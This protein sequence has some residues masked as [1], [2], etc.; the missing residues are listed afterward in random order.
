MSEY[1]K[2]D[3]V[4]KRDPATKNKTLILNDFSNPAFEYL[5]HNKWAFTEKVDGT[6]IRV[7]LPKYHENGL[8]YGITFGGKTEEAQIHTKLLVR[9]QERFMTVERRQ[10]LA[11]M[12]PHGAVLYGEGFGLGIQ[13][14]GQHYGAHQDFVLFDV[15][16]NDADT[17]GKTWW[18]ERRNVEDVA[19]KLDLPVVPIIGEGTLFDMVRMVRE[20]FPSQWG[21]EHGSFPAEGIVARPVV[22]LTDRAGKRI[23]TKL[24]H[25]DFRK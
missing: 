9:L 3:T 2:I 21:G 24:K 19:T 20:G 23:I 10:Q 25:K 5:A 14:M 17:P 11:Q 12:F 18:L 8:Q 7:M 22:E 4:F 13:K 16:V 1:H 6:N 15:L